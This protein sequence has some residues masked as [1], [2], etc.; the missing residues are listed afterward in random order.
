MTTP[1]PAPAQNAVREQFANPPSLESVTRQMLAAAIAR[2]VA[3]QQAQEQL[4]GIGFSAS[5]LDRLYVYLRNNARQAPSLEQAAQHFSVSQATLKRK[6][7]KHGTH[8]QAQ[9]DQARKTPW[10]LA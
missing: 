10:V 2:Q 9:Q 7:N 3:Y 5:L 8:F 6:L 4:Q 1:T